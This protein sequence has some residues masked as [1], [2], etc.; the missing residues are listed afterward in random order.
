[1]D[2]ATPVDD[3]RNRE[4]NVDQLAAFAP[5]HR[6][7]VLHLFATPDAL[8]NLEL[9]VHQPFGHDEHHRLSDGFRRRGAVDPLRAPVPGED[10]AVQGLTDNRI[11]RRADN[12]RQPARLLVALDPP[13]D[14]PG[15]VGNTGDL[16]ATVA[17]R[18][19]GQ[20]NVDQLAAF[21]PAHRLEML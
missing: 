6:F 8:Q 12:R 17:N 21:A 11:F 10:G 15:Y 16:A 18:R 19:D 20:R 13:D 3:R 2:A 9:F 4:R 7:E 5:P 14:V 1:H